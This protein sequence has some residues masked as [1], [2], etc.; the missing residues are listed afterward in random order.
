MDDGH[1]GIDEA[2]FLR[3]ANGS[4]KLGIQFCDWRARGE[5]YFHTFGDFGELSGSHSVRSQYHRLG[6]SGLGSL[7]EQC[8]PSAMASHWPE[9]TDPA[10]GDVERGAA[11]IA[12]APR[13]HRYRRGGHAHARTLTC[14]GV[15]DID[16]NH[17]L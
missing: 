3:A 4:Y 13:M 6:E 16:P 17:D 2:E 9:R 11:R 7:G 15:W 12:V 1:R 8:V 10:L 14:A 5:S